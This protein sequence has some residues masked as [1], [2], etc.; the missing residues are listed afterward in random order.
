MKLNSIFSK[1]QPFLSSPLSRNVLI[2][3]LY[4]EAI[5]NIDAKDLPKEAVVIKV[6]PQNQTTA[7]LKSEQ[8]QCCVLRIPQLHDCIPDPARKDK[9]TNGFINKAVEAHGIHYSI[10][11]LTS[12]TGTEDVSHLVKVGDIVPIEF[13]DGVPR[14]GNSKGQD[15]NYLFLEFISEESEDQEE[16]VD[17]AEL[18]SAFGK[19]DPKLLAQM[20][21]EGNEI[22][23]NSLKAAASNPLLA[24]KKV[25]N[26]KLPVAALRTIPGVFDNKGRKA[27]FLAEVSD[28][29]KLLMT[30]F[31]AHFGYP[32]PL[33]DTYRSYERQLKTKEETP[34]I[35]ADPGTSP[36]GWGLAFDYNTMVKQPDGTYIGSFDSPRYK[37]LFTNAPKRGFW[38]PGWAQEDGKMPEAWHFEAIKQD[39]YLKIFAARATIQAE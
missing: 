2:N 39:E 24:K 28:E 26:G 5:L 27:Q 12:T 23:T 1:I 25:T 16:E 15:P 8:Y 38:N 21:Q 20:S 33:T 11:P 4:Q 19:Q 36:H 35:A 22:S 34:D 32:L 9:K 3:D 14:F 18:Q 29:F 6:F 13:I 31:K 17:V 10:F 30:D 37:W 7:D